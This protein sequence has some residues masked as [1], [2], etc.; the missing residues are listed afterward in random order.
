MDGRREDLQATKGGLRKV[1]DMGKSGSKTSW[2]GLPVP[3]RKRFT[4]EEANRALPLVERVIRD[5]VSVHARASSLRHRLDASRPRRDEATEAELGDVL[6]RLHELMDEIKLIGCELK[7][8]QQGLVD[9]V[10]RHDGRDIYLCW[11]LGEDRISHWH[12]LHAG[13]AGRQ[14]VSALRG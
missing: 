6:R 2:V 7:D 13:V 10:S 11:K 12:E 9:F 14:C 5:M 4:L 3:P 1:V 8:C